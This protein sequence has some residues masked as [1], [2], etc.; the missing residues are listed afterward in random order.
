MPYS[1]NDKLPDAVKTALPSAAQSIFRRTFNSASEGGADEESAMKQA[2]GAVKNAGYRK[3]DGKWMKK[4]AEHFRSRSSTFEVRKIDEDQRLVFG[5]FS[6]VE[7]D[8]VAVVDDEGDVITPEELEKAAYNF[9]LKARIAG[10]RHVRKGV[11][12]LVES[13]M[14]TKEKQDALGINLGCVGWFGGFKVSDEDV[15]DSIRKG[16]YPMFSIGGKGTRIPMEE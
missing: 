1:S 4:T 7:K 3:R 14:F 10:D 6:V 15:W 11:G 2:W 16:D 9:V 8:G 5:W 12:D 13:I